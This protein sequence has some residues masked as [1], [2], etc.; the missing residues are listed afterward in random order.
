MLPLQVPSITVSGV[1]RTIVLRPRAAC[2]LALVIGPF[3]PLSWWV[4]LKAEGT[5]QSGLAA[6]T[7]SSHDRIWGDRTLT[8]AGR[9]E[10]PQKQ[11]GLTGH[12]QLITPLVFLTPTFVP[13]KNL[14]SF[15]TIYIVTYTMQVTQNLRAI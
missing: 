11:K 14:G 12:P 13:Q 2:G 10:E 9:E 3:F 6:V 7:V 4:A 5:A 8:G 1:S 15:L